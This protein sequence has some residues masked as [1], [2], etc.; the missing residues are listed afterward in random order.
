MYDHADTGPGF[1]ASTPEKDHTHRKMKAVEAWNDIR[2]SLVSS[3]I[4][5]SGF[6]SLPM[7]CVFCMLVC[8]A[9]IVGL[10]RFFVRVARQSYTTR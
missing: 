4:V 9:K 8:G 7:L 6:P 3:L 10:V 5:M 1:D 2:P